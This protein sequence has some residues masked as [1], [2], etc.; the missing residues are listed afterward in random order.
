MAAFFSKNARTII[1]IVGATACFVGGMKFASWR[2][3][4]APVAPSA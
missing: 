4:P 3:A 1:E 2:S